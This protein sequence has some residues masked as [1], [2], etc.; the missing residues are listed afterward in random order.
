MC[1]KATRVCVCVCVCVCVTITICA[2]NT[3]LLAL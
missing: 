2:I 1:M 3:K